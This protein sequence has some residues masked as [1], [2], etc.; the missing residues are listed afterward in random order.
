MGELTFPTFKPY[1]EPTVFKKKKTWN[2]HKD[3]QIDHCKRIGSLQINPDRC[4]Q[5][6]FD[7]GAKTIQ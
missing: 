7:K 2:Q 3:T 6:T 1:Y 5:T 4:S